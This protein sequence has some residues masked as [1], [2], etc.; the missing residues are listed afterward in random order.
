MSDSLLEICQAVSNESGISIDSSIIGSTDSATKQL[1]AMAN[2]I[3]REIGDAFPWPKLQ[4]QGSI[5]LVASQ[6]TYA[7]ASDINWI[8]HETV[9]NQNQQWL[10]YG[11]YTPQDR[12]LLESGIIESYPFQRFTVRGITS[13]Q[14]EIDPTPTASEDGEVLAYEYNALRPVKPR[15]WEAGQSVGSVGEYT[16]YNGNY[17]KSTNTGTTGSTPPTHTS[18]SASDDTI[19]WT[20]YDGTYAEF[21]ADTDEPIINPKTFS[22]GLLERF[23]SRHG[24]QVE[25]RYES[26]LQRDIE[27]AKPGRIVSMIRRPRR[28]YPNAPGTEW[29]R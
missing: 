23:S 11:P 16:F 19:T 29:A 12:Q 7:L 27:Q 21:L 26:L 10:L 2:R 24:V 5:T 3:A 4:K 6:D 8:Y 17:Y 20:Y 18:G 1:L 22:Q 28:R 25:P 9:W 15:T 14:F 13:R